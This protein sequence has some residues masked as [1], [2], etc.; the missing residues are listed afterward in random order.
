MILGKLFTYIIALFSRKSFFLMITEL[1]WYE[2]IFPKQY[3]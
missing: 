1:Q 2:T 3:I